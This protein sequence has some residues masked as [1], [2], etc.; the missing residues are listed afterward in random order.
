MRL[1]MPVL[2][3][4]GYSEASVIRAT[5]GGWF[6]VLGK[7]ATLLSKRTWPWLSTWK[8][9]CKCAAEATGV[10]LVGSENTNWLAA[11]TP[12]TV[13]L[14]LFKSEERRVGKEWRAWWSADSLKKYTM[15]H[16]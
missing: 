2:E 3:K 5:P 7:T 15:S 9:T 6:V 10:V 1:P 13:S 11:F 4:F 16:V 8:I 14:T 12:P